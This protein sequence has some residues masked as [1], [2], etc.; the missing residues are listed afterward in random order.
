[1]SMQQIRQGLETMLEGIPGVK[2]ASGW[3]VEQVNAAPAAFVGFDD[4]TVTMGNLELDMH[5]LPITFLVQRK[6]GN[7]KNQVVAVEALIDDFKAAVRANQKL[8]LPDLVAGT[9]YTHIREGIYEMGG[10]PYVGFIADITVKT[11]QAVSF[12]S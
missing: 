12:G 10:T 6:A 7:L 9:R 3:P 1:M 5:A 11:T 4:D 2:S 8:G